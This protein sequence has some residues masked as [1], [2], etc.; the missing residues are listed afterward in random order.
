MNY[1]KRKKTMSEI[2]FTVEFQQVLAES[3]EK[4]QKVV[5]HGDKVLKTAV[6]HGHIS[7]DQAI[8]LIDMVNNLPT[9]ESILAKF[10][11]A[12]EGPTCVTTRGM[13]RLAMGD[14]FLT[15]EEYEFLMAGEWR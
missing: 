1:S 13:V 4:A 14:A 10:V 7:V 11:D 6:E 2:Q 9:V 5:N 12:M 8:I 15:P 3:A